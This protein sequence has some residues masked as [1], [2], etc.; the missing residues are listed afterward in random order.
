VRWRLVEGVPDEDLR[1]LLAVAR[2]RT[3]SRHEV[4]FHRDDPA[5]SLH[6]I[7]KGRF[8]IRIIT[9]FGE[10]AT[11]AIRRPGDTF[12]EMA[13]VA[14]GLKRSATVEALDEAETFAVHVDDFRRLRAEHPSVNQV[15]I[16]FLADEVRRQ[17]ALL[18]ETLYVPA[19]RRVVRRLVELA[20][21]AADGSIRFTQEQ[22]AELAG[23]SR[24]TVNRVLRDEQA[25]G[26]LRLA[27]GTV[28]VVDRDALERRAG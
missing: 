14:E 3:F 16:Q 18:L 24:A 1:R 10:T 19:E 8:A 9:P 17:N 28:A 4:V 12:G 22:I 21:D 5:D 2:R 13:L 27:R 26:S 11:I 20:A 23:T 6:L 25:R 7:T 15:L